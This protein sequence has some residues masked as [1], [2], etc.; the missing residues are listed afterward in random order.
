[1]TAHDRTLQQPVAARAALSARGL[2]KRFGDFQAIDD[3]TLEVAEGTIHALIGPNG[4]GK[5]TLFGLLTKFIP[6]TSG[7]ITLGGTD[8]TRFKPEEVVRQGMVR[9]FQIS[10]VFPHLSL[11]D[12]V[13]VALQHKHGLDRQFWL[14]ERRLNALNGEVDALLD[15]VGLSDLAG[16]LAS[17]VSYGRKRALELATTLALDPQVMLLDEPMA[18]MASAD[19][20]TIADLIRRSGEGRTI[21]MV[22]HNL[23]VVEDLCD[24]VTVLARGAVL[25]EG[26]FDE[27]RASQEVRE[28]YMGAGHD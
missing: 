9:S 10:A 21:I 26:S 22:E 2:S 16:R 19:I 8:I 13:R 17:E 4:A 20:G 6:P 5:S 1:M 11:R 28:S 3:V 24:R 12:N 7:T 25:A 18:G 23:D 27:I 15:K 14:P